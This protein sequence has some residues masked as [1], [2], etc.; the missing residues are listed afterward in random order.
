MY[1]IK[2]KE[3][4]ALMEQYS[5]KYCKNFTNCLKHAFQLIVAAR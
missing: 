3:R 1:Y 2:L 4:K 5:V